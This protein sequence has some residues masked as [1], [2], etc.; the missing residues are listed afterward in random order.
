MRASATTLEAET[1]EAERSTWVEPLRN[2]GLTGMHL[3][4]GTA[5]GGTLKE[6][7]K[8]YP[9]G[10]R[11]RFV[12]ID[13][14]TYFPNQRDIIERNLRVSGLDPAD[15]DFRVGYSWPALQDALAAR[16][17]FSFIFVDGDHSAKGTMQDLVWTRMLEV[18]GLVALH[19]YRPKFRGVIW[20][21]ER[22][23]RQHSNYEKIARV[24]GLVIL[25]KTAMSE[26][27]EVTAFDIALADLMKVPLK[28][29]WSVE[30]RLFPARP[31]HS[32]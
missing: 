7:M 21:V 32:A 27:S 29:L 16:E 30:K 2:A 11:P 14:L 23:L 6:L 15:I 22:F 26:V 10:A 25:R 19:D 17:S 18:G 3:E 1:T 13:P 8:I 12:V 20:A 9:N 4:I 24:E 31:P 28:W 5:A